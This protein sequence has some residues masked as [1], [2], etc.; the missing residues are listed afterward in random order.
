MPKP[1]NMTAQ[2]GIVAAAATAL[3]V[4]GSFM[5]A[6][7][8]PT[9]SES[10]AATAT[11]SEKAPTT[12]GAVDTSG[13]AEAIE[14]D[15]GET[16]EEYL[17]DAK[18]TAK[19]SKIKAALR[20]A[21]I[22][23]NVV[24]EDGVVVVKVG[25]ADLAA[26]KKII[27]EVEAT[28]TAKA[29]EKSVEASATATAESEAKSATT[30]ASPAEA[31]EKAKDAA[32]NPAEFS[33]E[34]E[35]ALNVPVTLESTEVSTI[36]EVLAMLKETAAPSALKELT[37]VTIDAYGE[38]I[39]RAGGAGQTEKSDA[40]KA[41]SK[42]PHPQLSLED[43]VDLLE[44]AT[45]KEAEDGGPATPAAAEDVYGGMGYATSP[46]GD[47]SGGFGVCSLGFNAWNAAGED[48]VITAG[49]CTTDGSM[50]DVAVL[51]HDAVDSYSAI[52]I[53]LGT[54]GFSQFGTENN[55][56]YPWDPQNAPDWEVGTDIAVIDAI[57]PAANLHPGV[58]KW[59][60]GKDERDE[61]INVTSDG[62]GIV[63]QDACNSG[64]TTGWQ[65]SELLEEG[66][67]FVAGFDENGN[68]T[69]QSVRTVWGYTA[70]SPDGDTLLPGD[71]GG[72]VVQG[73]RAI[74]INS[75][76]S[77]NVALYTSLVDAQS[78]TPVGEYDVKLFVPTPV[79]TAENGAEVEAGEAITGTVE[80]AASG[81]EVDIIVD[82]KVIATVPVTDGRFTFNAPEELGEF[83][84]TV[85]AKNGYDKS[86]AA[87]GNV[88]IV[89]A[90]TPTPTEEPT[91]DPTEEPTV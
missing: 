37:S 44:G 50:K 24:V 30:S 5:P 75:A 76:Y 60:D 58:T 71:S 86:A 19:A 69:D 17:E 13:L 20:A 90:P 26:S 57:N 46:N 1:K 48:A 80:G 72:A 41:A 63:G 14:R 85:Q 4:G 74:G 32:K 65:C 6:T 11:A 54:F 52:G 38:V 42:S 15:L 64:R 83:S 82:G 25:K 43:A 62:E 89:A 29:G 33:A 16:P 51:E 66:V 35:P 36:D 70:A 68:S 67:F 49:H 84:F 79:I 9:A 39:V 91:V 59:A 18:V 81:T 23:T 73:T 55:G 10:P 2:R 77:G 31:T 87:S 53:H 27:A 78:K 40:S 34:S 12:E 47:Y 28:E 22:D 8:A 61:T 88:V 56:G 45:L 21:E 3:V 7:A